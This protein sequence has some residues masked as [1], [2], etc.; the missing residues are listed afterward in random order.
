MLKELPSYDHLNST[1]NLCWL[2]LTLVPWQSVSVANSDLTL[3]V[4]P[5]ISQL[6]TRLDYLGLLDSIN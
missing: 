5:R 1:T 3:L 2:S 4:S 6:I